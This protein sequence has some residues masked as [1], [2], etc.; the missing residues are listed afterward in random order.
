MNKKLVAYAIL[1]VVGLALFGTGAIS[2]EAWGGSG[3]GGGMGRQGG[4]HGQGQG[5]GL[6]S[7]EVREQVR[8]MSFDERAELRQER[9]EFR[10]QHREEM[11]NFTGISHEEMR[12]LHWNGG[13]VGDILKSKGITEAEAEKFLTDEA[14]ERVDAIV[15]RH[16]LDA[17][18]EETLRD[19]VSGFVDRILNRWFG[20]N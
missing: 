11:E 12:E 4:M 19:R 2:A 20:S 3:F 17:D 9:A 18:A 7:E 16:D 6:V 13:S 14:E 15:E 10:D 5:F 8:S 1:P